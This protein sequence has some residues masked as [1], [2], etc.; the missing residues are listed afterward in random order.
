MQLHGAHPSMP[1]PLCT[2]RSPRRHVKTFGSI[3][4]EDLRHLGIKLGDEFAEVT[5]ISAWQQGLWVKP[6]PEAQEHLSANAVL[7]A[8]GLDVPCYSDWAFKRVCGE[9]QIREVTEVPACPSTRTGGAA[10][11]TILALFTCSAARTCAALQT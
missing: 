10:S 2:L 9:W 6:T 11:A 1:S 8:R 5:L 7:K 3:E 4:Y